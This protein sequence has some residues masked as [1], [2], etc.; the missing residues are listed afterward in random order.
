MTT[1]PEAQDRR[2][3][4]GGDDAYSHFSDRRRRFLAFLLGYVTLASSLTA[5]IYFPLIELLSTQYATSVQAI[6]LT[7]TL[8]V[9]FQAVSPALFAPL[10]D[11]FG[12]R[13]VLLGTFALYA[14]AGLGL[15]LNRTSYAALLVLRGLQSLGGSAVLALAYGVV[16]DVVA[17]SERGRMLGPLMA[18]TNLG[19]CAGPLLG[20]AIAWE[21][22]RTDWCFWTLVAF[23]ATAFFLIGWTLPETNRA[24]VGNGSVDARGVWRTW[25]EVLLRLLRRRGQ[26]RSKEQQMADD[27][28]LESRADRGTTANGRGKLI[29]PNPLGPLRIVFY[30]DTALTLW[31]AAVVYTVWYCIQTSIPVI[32]G[33]I[34]HFNN[35]QVGLS[36]LA[37]GSGVIA[38]GFLAGRLMD[39]N[40][41]VVAVNHGLPT[42]HRKGD[43][44][45]DF[46]IEKARARGCLL[47][48]GVYMCEVVAFGWLVHYE[49]H[50][51]ASL[52]LQFFIGAH[53]TMIHQVFNALLVD[54][55]PESPSTAAAA[56]NITRC[57]MSA[58]VVAFMEPLVSAIGRGC[59][60]TLIGLLSSL[61]GM[62]AVLILT[63]KGHAWRKQRLGVKK[64]ETSNRT[65]MDSCEPKP[66]E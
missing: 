9:V 38:G 17:S 32:Y 1:N 14:A 58:A 15:A 57:G 2:A 44:I 41:R 19:P 35:F 3:E 29:I 12:R 63:R 61:S 46:P 37:G 25:W 18:A 53:G 42:D 39:W 28:D 45:Y 60:F 27:G 24:I 56:G 16:A 31:T 47:N 50:F 49:V 34:Y 65:V 62:A 59:F 66:K 26:F 21:T 10:S 13:P 40:Y 22:G 43:D 48:F 5:T 55:F 6:N 30:R 4:T 51:S 52:V 54:I 11:S 36:Y 8:Y 23:G 64:A 20:G 7:I 33:P